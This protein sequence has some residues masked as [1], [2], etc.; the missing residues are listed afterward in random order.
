MHAT[1]EGK[2]VSGAERIVLHDRIE[3]VVKELEERALERGC[4]RDQISLTVEPIQPPVSYRV[5]S[6]DVITLTVED[7]DTARVLAGRIL[8]RAG[9]SGQA[10]RSAI[11]HINA[12]ASGSNENMRGAMIVDARSG[13][14]LERDTDRGVRASKFDWTDASRV[15][16]DCKLNRIGLTHFRTREA[17]A[18]ATKVAHGPGIVAEL[19]WSDEPDYTVGYAA[20]IHAGYVRFPVLKQRGDKK[21][22]RAFFVNFDAHDLDALMYY[23]EKEPVL[24][25]QVGACSPSISPDVYFGHA[26]DQH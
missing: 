14:R 21:G 17:L 1:R 3:A 5:T 16:V 22:G 20:S 9:V 19:C 7:P 18:L 13:A 23:L 25:E 6:L 2:H 8:Q 26:P 10:I 12:G 24:I 4:T 11:D 15:V